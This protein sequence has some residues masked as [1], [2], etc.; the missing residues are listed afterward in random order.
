MLR[1]IS[2]VLTTTVLVGAVLV[3][4]ISFMSYVVVLSN[5]QRVEA[6]IRSLTA[7]KA[8]NTVMYIEKVVGDSNTI[9][10]YVGVINILKETTV[11]GITTFKTD[12]YGLQAKVYKPLTASLSYFNGSVFT[13]L[14]SKS[15]DSSKVY[16]V[17]LSGD[18]VPLTINTIDIYEYTYRHTGLI[19]IT[20]SKSLLNTNDYVVI[21]LLATVGDEHYEILQL[22]YQVRL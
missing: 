9:S 4:G 17:S 6:Y 22:S 14:T 1:G 3:V 5:N 11:Y 20:L 13:S 10:L 18:Y 19:N 15:V 2:P 12:Y 16:I 7:D 8:L 21:M